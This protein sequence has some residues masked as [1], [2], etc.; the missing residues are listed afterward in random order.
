MMQVSAEA[1]TCHIVVNISFVSGDNPLRRQNRQP[2]L[3]AVGEYPLDSEG[4]VAASHAHPRS[5]GSVPR[6]V[7][8]G[9]THGEGAATGSHAHDAGKY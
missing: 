6:G 4:G 9:H 2:Q 3:G 1:I 5:P 8:A 7:A